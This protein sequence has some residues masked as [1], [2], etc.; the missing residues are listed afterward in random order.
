[1]DYDPPEV[2]ALVMVNA[3]SSVTFVRVIDGKT[4]LAGL[5][6]EFV[7]SLIISPLVMD[8]VI[9]ETETIITVILSKPSPAIEDDKPAP[10]VRETD[11]EYIT[12]WIEAVRYNELIRHKP[13]I[14]DLY[15][16]SYPSVGQYRTNYYRY[17]TDNDLIKL[18]KLGFSLPG[19]IFQQ[20]LQRQVLN[21]LNAE[22]IE[23]WVVDYHPRSFDQA[24]P[25]TL[26][27]AGTGDYE[28]NYARGEFYKNHFLNQ[29]DLFLAFSFLV[30]N[31]YWLEQLSGLSAWRVYTQMPISTYKLSV[32]YDNMDQTLSSM[33]LNPIYW[34]PFVFGIDHNMRSLILRA[35]TPLFDMGVHY[36]RERMQATIFADDYE[37][38]GWQFL[39]ARQWKNDMVDLGLR[40]EKSL[41][42]RNYDA[43]F[44]S[45]WFDD[46]LDLSLGYQGHPLTA[47][48]NLQWDDWK[49]L[50]IY[51]DLTYDADH[52]LAGIYAG[53]RSAL[54]RSFDRSVNLYL[55]DAI[56][57]SVNIFQ[58]YAFAPYFSWISYPS[59][60]INFSLGIQHVINNLPVSTNQESA[61]I[62]RE[63][64]LFFGNV[65]GTYTYTHGS[66]EWRAEHILN[67]QEPAD[68]LR[69]YQVWRYQGRLN[70]TR[71]LPRKNAIFGGLA[72]IG[73]SSYIS[74]NE[75]ALIIDNSA[76]MDIWA[77]V[78]ISDLFE[79]TL[80]VQNL[81]EGFYYGSYP[82]PRSIHASLTWFYLN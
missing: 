39:I 65:S 51:G 58:R 70:L 34:Q 8:G 71:H 37:Q 45:G 40:Y 24:V 74:S 1:L 25:L 62:R 50:Q 76:V 61:N 6:G 52:Y 11:K 22:R 57:N 9:Q 30:Q 60:R 41:I 32:Y 49:R 46:R 59:M 10:D 2:R 73:H 33:Q 20:S 64:E 63:K 44:S 3:D 80:S 5:L 26:I 42:E 81:N 69:E 48:A 82:I 78:R 54:P 56:L 43:L 66:Y 17:G 13:L 79:F 16:R 4:E 15:P 68:K 35:E 23:R 27:Q 7:G 77:G 28:F 18:R 75:L 21:A 31:G 29:P 38:S 72:L 53:F 47:S 19:S 36:T 55:A 12:Q 14:Q 67:W